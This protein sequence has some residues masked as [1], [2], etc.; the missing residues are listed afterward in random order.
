MQLLWLEGKALIIPRPQNQH[1][2]H[3]RYTADAPIYVTTLA[4]D[5]EQ[6]KHGVERGDLAMLAKRLLVFRFTRRVENPKRIPACAKCWASCVLSSAVQPS[7]SPQPAAAAGATSSAAG[8]PP[9]ASAAWSV[10]DVCDWLLTLDLP[11]VQDNF[12]LN[13]VDG[14]FLATLT[15]EDLV[16][17][18]GLTR[19]QARKVLQRLP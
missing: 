18:L 7:A 19:L 1:V 14:Q 12:R 5:L 13:G 10:N 17:E 8:Q 2:G 11:H 6:V 15:E 4:A 9:R 16:Q 3:L